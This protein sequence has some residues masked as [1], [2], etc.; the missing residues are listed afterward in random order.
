MN[1]ICLPI[2][3]NVG[4]PTACQFHI[5]IVYATELIS[6]RDTNFPA[7]HNP[8]RHSSS[9]ASENTITNFPAFHNPIRDSSSVASVASENT[10]TN[11]PAFHNPV[12]DSS[13]VA[14]VE[15][16]CTSPHAV[17]YANNKTN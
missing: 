2:Q 14:L 12:R 13:S 3:D 7:F 6:L 8:V 16:W 1:E 4:I 9:V 5:G 17:R 15:T 11:F 10:T